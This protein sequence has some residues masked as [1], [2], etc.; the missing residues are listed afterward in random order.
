MFIEI[1]IVL[2]RVKPS[3]L[4]LNT[5]EGGGLRGLRFLDFARLEMFI[6]EFLASV[7]FL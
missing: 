3:V 7:H 6:N 4:F 1:A 2:E 5:E